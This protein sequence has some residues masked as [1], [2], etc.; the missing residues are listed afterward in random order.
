M[1]PLRRFLFAF[2]CLSTIAPIGAAVTETFGTGKGGLTAAG[3][4][5]LKLMSPEMRASVRFTALSSGEL[6]VFNFGANPGGGYFSGQKNVFTVAL[7]ADEGGM[8]GREI[9]R[10]DETVFNDG[11]ARVRTARFAPGAAVRAGAAYHLVVAAPLADA[12]AHVFGLEYAF[13]GQAVVPVNSIDMEQVD[14]VAG[15]LDSSDG[16]AS[17][18][19][20]KSAIAAHEIVIGVKSQGWGYTGTVELPIKRGPAGT[21]Y[22]MQSFRF[23]TRGRAGKAVPQRLHLALRPQG[24]LTGK[25]VKVFA[26]IVTPVG[27]QTVA[28]AAVTVTLPNASRFD[29]VVLPFEGGT[30]T[31]GASYVLIVG[32]TEEVT[33]APKDFLFMR[34]YSWGIG[35]PNLHEVS[36]QGSAGCASVSSDASAQGPVI[37]G[38]DVPFLIDYQ[39]VK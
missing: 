39:P 14:P 25:P 13:L 32:L 36:W 16:G 24:A 21:Q 33:S 28:E 5:S 34:G 38:A 8:P 7:H 17:W 15:V 19:P 10:A 20:V 1:H 37:R 31:E 12:A 29:P 23:T 26:E 11:G 22:V 30:M 3:S 27:F 6:S 9:A 18:A 2:V 4:G 35:S